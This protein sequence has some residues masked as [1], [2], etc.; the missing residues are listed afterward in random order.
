MTRW[1]IFF[2]AAI[3]AVAGISAYA[4]RADLR[5]RWYAVSA[6]S[7]PVA[8]RFSPPR[9]IGIEQTSLIEEGVATSQHFMLVTS[10]SVRTHKAVDPFAIHG[11]LP[12]ELNLAVPFTSQ[13]PTGE[14]A[15]PYQEACEE[16]SAI[17][18]DAFYRG[19]TGRIPPDVATKAITNLV[20]FEKKILGF[21]EDTSA[22]DTAKF[23]KAYFGYPTV[24]IQPLTSESELK[25]AIA[26][27]YPVIIPAAGKLLPNPYFRA[28]G[29]LYHMLVVKGYTKDRIITN[30][31]GTKRGADF[32][33]T[34]DQLKHAAH[35]WNGGDV[36]HGAPVM[37]VVIPKA[38]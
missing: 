28:G 38:S 8:I 19:E 25:R 14:W 18:V 34:F 27:G 11:L 9:G 36:M 2:F 1:K 6:P 10:P 31:P 30:D 13:A 7:V 16:A 37:L 15:L 35:D 33:Y 23:I 4:F 24:M 12:N 29:P 17:M 26:N 20:A 32:T 3:F 21:Y 5:E 22:L